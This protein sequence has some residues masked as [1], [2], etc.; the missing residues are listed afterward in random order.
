MSHGNTRKQDNEGRIKL[1]ISEK[2]HK[3]KE[4]LEIVNKSKQGQRIKIKPELGSDEYLK[5]NSLSP[6]IN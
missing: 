6:N 5:I 4:S 1:I 3:E 2:A